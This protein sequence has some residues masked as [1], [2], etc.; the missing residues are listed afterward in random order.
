LHHESGAPYKYFV[1][2]DVKIEKNKDD[3][4][5]LTILKSDKEGVFITELTI[6]KEF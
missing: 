5:H 1:T 6:E 2:D 3:S 4:H